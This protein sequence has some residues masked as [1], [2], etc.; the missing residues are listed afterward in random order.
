MGKVKRQHMCISA[1][2]LTATELMKQTEILEVP[3]KTTDVIAQTPTRQSWEHVAAACIVCI[4]AVSAQLLWAC[5]SPTVTVW[6]Y[7]WLTAF[8]TGLGALPLLLFAKVD[9]WWTGASNAIAGGMMI[10]TSGALLLEGFQLPGPSEANKVVLGAAVGSAFMGISEVFLERYEHLKCTLPSGLD[11]RKALLVFVVMFVHS[12]SEGIGIG[13]SFKTDQK[14]LGLI[15]S[16]T[17]AVHNIPE[18]FAVAV[19][20]MP[21]GVTTLQA[22]VWGVLSSSP[23]PIMA[24]IANLFVDEFASILPVGLGFAAGAMVWV[25]CSELLVDATKDTS[26]RQTVV[27]AL[28][29]GATM[30]VLQQC[31]KEHL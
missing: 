18:G 1:T 10:S 9:R 27:I 8:S 22:A 25:A 12:F 21:H 14:Q 24:L 13:V 15:V 11:A 5:S 29:A 2:T 28:C 3:K 20:M 4:T 30:L 16:A 19:A 23:Q 7:G 26:I 17:L 31:M 6:W